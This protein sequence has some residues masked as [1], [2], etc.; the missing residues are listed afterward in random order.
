M[1]ANQFSASPVTVHQKL[2]HSGHE[3]RYKFTLCNAAALQEEWNFTQDCQLPCQA[4]PTSWKFKMTLERAENILVVS[5]TAKLKRYD[6]IDIPVRVILVVKIRHEKFPD[7]IPI[8]NVDK[9]IL[10]GEELI[11]NVSNIVPHAYNYLLSE[12]LSVR[13]HIYVRDCH[14][15]IRKDL[16]KP[17]DGKKKEKKSVCSEM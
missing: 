2:R 4:T 12:E 14:R 10:P 6:S 5:G 3:V 11:I 9:I 16:G 8:P 13:V 7:Y 1:A 17:D 15:H